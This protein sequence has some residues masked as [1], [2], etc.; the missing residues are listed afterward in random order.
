MFRFDFL[1]PRVLNTLRTSSHGIS[2]S[3]QNVFK[4]FVDTMISIA[5]YIMCSPFLSDLASSLSACSLADLK[6]LDIDASEISII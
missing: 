2:Q 3:K 6:V 1:V 4:V 5:Q